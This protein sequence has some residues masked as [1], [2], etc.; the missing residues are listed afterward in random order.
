MKKCE[1][2]GYRE[3]FKFKEAVDIPIELQD[4]DFCKKCFHR[5]KMKDYFGVLPKD[6]KEEKKDE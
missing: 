4:K 1:I 6:K 3:A 2:C 5:Y